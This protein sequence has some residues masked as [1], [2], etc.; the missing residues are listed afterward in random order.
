MAAQQGRKLTQSIIASCTTHCD[1]K[2]GSKLNLFPLSS[3][4]GVDG[5]ET[6][7]FLQF[8]SVAAAFV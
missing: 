6:D 7:I 3:L 2:A 1:F 4:Q 5:V 8:I